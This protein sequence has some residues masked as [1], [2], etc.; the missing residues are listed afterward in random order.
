[1][2]ERDTCVVE[3]SDGIPCSIG[4]CPYQIEDNITVSY[5]QGYLIWKVIVKPN[6]SYFS[7]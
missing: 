3:A 4:N 7:L 1:M 6:P 2:K 5:K